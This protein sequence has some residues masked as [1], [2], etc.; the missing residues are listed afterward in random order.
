VNCMP[1]DNCCTGI[2]NCT[3]TN[4]RPFNATPPTP[5]YLQLAAAMNAAGEAFVASG[6]TPIGF[7]TSYRDMGSRS[8]GL[9]GVWDVELN[10]YRVKT[11]AWNKYRSLAGGA[12]STNPEACWIPGSYFPVDFEYDSTLRSTAPGDWAYAHYKGS[13]APGERIMGVSKSIA[14][15]WGRLGICYKDPLDSGRYQ[16]PNPDQQLR[17]TVRNVTAG[18]DRGAVSTTDVDWDPGN[19][20]AECAPDEYVAGVA[21]SLAHQF[22]HVL[23]CPQTLS[24]EHRTCETV[25]FGSGDNRQDN[26]S[27]NWDAAGHKGECGVGR[28][29]AGVSRTPAGQPN[30]LLCCTQ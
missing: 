8:F 30:A 22:S 2:E 11:A 29:V 27:G 9:R 4:S 13:C 10:K 19:W 5:P 3:L 20:K 16:N 18:D 23:C 14:S 24:P 28:Y 7:W 26:S 21:Q 25:A 1:E 12:G 17:C 15:G 6:V